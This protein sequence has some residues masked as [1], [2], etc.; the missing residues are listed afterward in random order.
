[1]RAGVIEGFYGRTWTAAERAGFLRG[2][3]DLPGATHIYAPK[4]DRGL[5][6][7]WAQPL[8]DQHLDEL[9]AMRELCRELGLRFGVGIS[10]L[11]LAADIESPARA[12][13]WR[14]K[15]RQLAVLQCDELWLLFDDM[16]VTR[17]PLAAA[18][19]Q[20]YEMFA[21]EAGAAKLAVCPGFY[22]FDP[23]LEKLFGPRP[24]DYWAA[25]GGGLPP[26]TDL[27]WTGNGV[28]NGCITAADCQRARDALGR[29]PVIWDNYPVNDGRRTADFLHLGAFSGRDF[30]GADAARGHFMNPMVQPALSGIVLRSFCDLHRDPAAYDPDVSR[31]AAFA[32]LPVP[33][34]SLLR[35]DW[36]RFAEQ[37]RSAIAAADRQDLQ[38]EYAGCAHPAAAEVCRWLG[39]DYCF[40][41]EVLND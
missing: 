15:L 6:R 25:L 5:R 40:D 18:Q 38:R 8:T 30:V 19:L 29:P 11:G 35:R 17:T 26:E 9:C 13:Q 10:P 12:G 22:T 21:A 37:G 4:G 23:V 41:P 20:I 2:L 16:P 1:M 14:T 32:S 24:A 28:L 27:L 39:G 34:A 3:A 33:L 7:D 31:Q 36:R